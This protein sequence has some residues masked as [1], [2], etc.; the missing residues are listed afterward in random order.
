MRDVKA[1]TNVVP[2][3]KTYLHE[4]GPKP[5]LQYGD[6]GEMRPENEFTGFSAHGLSRK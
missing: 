1:S 6:Y 4:Y 2:T 3:I 5:R